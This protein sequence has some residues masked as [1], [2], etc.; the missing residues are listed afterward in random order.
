[1]AGT[2]YPN[3][4]LSKSVLR[5]VTDA[6]TLTKADNGKV[7]LIN[8]TTT[9]I[10]TLPSAS[11]VSGMQVRIVVQTAATSGNGHQISPQSTDSIIESSFTV[12]DDKDAI[13]T[14]ATGK[15]GDSLHLV[16]NGADW[17]VI[18][19]TGVWARQG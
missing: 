18:G 11:S 12:A 17:V 13:N 19:K 8:S 1:M 7:I 10:I 3:G 5:T 4:V 9:R 16:S 2:R 6:T 15:A 14:Q